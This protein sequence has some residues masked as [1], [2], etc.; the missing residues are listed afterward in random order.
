[1]ELFTDP[2]E[3]DASY[4][5]AWLDAVRTPAPAAV[6]A[7]NFL[8]VAHFPFVHAGTF[9]AAAEKVVPRYQVSTEP[10]GCRSMQEQWFDNPEDPGVAAGIRS[11][12]QRRRATY[13]YRAP[14]QLMLRL[15]ELDAGAVKT[16]LF[17]AQP[18]TMTSTRLYTKMLLH[19]IG[20]I[21]RPSA[22]LVAREVAFE[23][24][25]LA[26]DLALH[27]TMRLPGLP[28]A[29]RDEMHVRADLLGVALRRTL[30][31]FVARATTVG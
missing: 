5:G 23:T 31:D 29:L 21:G 2:D 28:L 11:S 6:A 22:D 25:V 30:A 18:E 10:Y 1:V 24:S 3:E 14:F 4:V 13:V 8:D 16:I 26:E 27:E 19:G 17:F 20:G 7:D 12:R 9:G 15:S